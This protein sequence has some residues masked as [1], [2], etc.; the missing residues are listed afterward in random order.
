ME[1]N[2]FK[3]L[4]W[5]TVSNIHLKHR[6]QMK[7]HGIFGLR[8]EYWENCY[9]SDCHWSYIINGK[10]YGGDFGFNCDNLEHGKKL[11][12]DRYLEI[13]NQI[14]ETICEL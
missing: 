10:K 6:S 3:K 9:N 2:K 8:F 7:V 11:C 13:C 4:T 1:E 5:K 14:L 12:E